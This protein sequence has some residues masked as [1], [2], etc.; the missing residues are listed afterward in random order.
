MGSGEYYK[1]LYQLK[2]HPE[3]G[4][5]AVFYKS[6]DDVKIVNGRYGVGEIYRPE[7]TS[8]YY[9]L[10]NRQFSAFHEVNSPEIWHYYT[11]NSSIHL[12]LFEEEGILSKRVLGDPAIT[13]EA[14][15]QL[16]VAANQIFAAELEAKEEDSFALVGCTVSPGFT[17]PDFKLNSRVELLQKYPQH[18]EII[19]RLTRSAEL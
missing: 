12:Y 17:F 3:G 10:S 11:G 13:K 18:S 16:L 7:G 2:P 6:K 5:Y 19:T 9:M 4:D 15:F 14:T 8:I 1:T